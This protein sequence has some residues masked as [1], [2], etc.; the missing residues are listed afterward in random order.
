MPTSA[1]LFSWGVLLI[2]AAF[3]VGVLAAVTGVGWA[4]TV[5]VALLVV[6]MILCLFGA[7]AARRTM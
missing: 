4:Y 7:R 2:M 3:F 1:Y 5:A 6:G